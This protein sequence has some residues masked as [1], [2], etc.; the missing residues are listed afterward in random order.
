MVTGNEL[1]QRY[2]YDDDRLVLNPWTGLFSLVFF[3]FLF[4]SGFLLIYSFDYTAAGFTTAMGIAVH[5]SS[6]TPAEL[7]L[8]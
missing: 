4:V 7:V 2:F 3:F 1:I 5:K 6:P 8:D